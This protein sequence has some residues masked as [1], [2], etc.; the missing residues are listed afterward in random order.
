L[1]VLIVDTIISRKAFQFI[2]K[3]PYQLFQ[4][5]KDYYLFIYL[6]LKEEV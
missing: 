3:D 5:K 4:I 1:F 2:A 6:S